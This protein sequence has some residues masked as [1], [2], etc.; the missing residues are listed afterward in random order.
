MKD[1]ISA[2]KEARLSAYAPYSNFLVGAAI[3]TK[4]GKIFT[5]CNIENASYSLTCCAERV[6]ATSAIAQGH[7]DFEALAVVT[8]SGA[9]PCGAC[10]QFLSEFSPDLAIVTANPHGNLLGETTLDAI[11]PA[12]FDKG[13][14]NP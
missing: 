2:A 10:R 11:F 14:L 12:A 7:L 4:T 9:Y 1:L 8:T 3:L 13:N 5:G 6:A